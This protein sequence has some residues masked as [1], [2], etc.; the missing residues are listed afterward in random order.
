MQVFLTVG[1]S[2][3]PFDRLVKAVTP[4]C[5]E[6]VV[7]AQTGMSTVRLPC[8]S[9]RFLPYEEWM[10]RAAAADVVI[11]HAGNSVRLIQ[12]LGKV[13]I[14]VP[15][16]A[17]HAEMGNDHQVEYL[18]R[19]ERLGRVVAA[20]DVAALPAM[21][22]GHADAERRIVSERPLAPPADGNAVADLIDGLWRQI[23][24]NPFKTHPLQR[25]R[26]AWG[27]LA[28]RT[29][30]HLDLGFGDGVF[31]TTLTE[32]SNLRCTGADPHP[33]SVERL[34]VRAPALSVVRLDVSRPLPF[35]DESFDS[36]SLLDVLEHC[37][38]E[39][40]LLREVF[41]I[42]RPGGALVV[43][44]PRLHVFSWLDPD[45]FKFSAPR[46][47]RRV[48]SARFGHDVYHERFVDL[49]DGL[50]GDMSV[51]R[52]RHTNYRRNQLRDLLEGTG[53]NVVDVS[54]ANLLWRLFHVPSLL[55]RGRLRVLLE[56]AIALDGRA[57]SS[58][59]LFVTVAK[60]R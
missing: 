1:M 35:D 42:V 24:A 33:P 52:R 43:S 59:N 19:E 27:R 18:R 23:A 30:E 48:Y 28:G 47:H 9:S 20:W 41:R 22:A 3:W 38:D 50:F 31:L 36:V 34:R 16:M 29:G 14:A 5:S 21:V 55:A 10:T 60:P 4:L 49:S 26:Y 32:T 54:G 51:G 15:R 56:R 37:P 6:H 13:P 11:T 39:R 2:R 44:V 7:F 8:T 58:A 17:R 40:E 12:R 25:Y 57:F 45:N 53:F 46:L